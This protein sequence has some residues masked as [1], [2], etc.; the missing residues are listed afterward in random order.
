MAI[1]LDEYEYDNRIGRRISYYASS[2][3]TGHRQFDTNVLPVQGLISASRGHFE[4][5][6]CT[7][8]AEF[9]PRTLILNRIRTATYPLFPWS[10][11]WTRQGARVKRDVIL[12]NLSLL[13][14]KVTRTT[15]FRSSVQI[16]QTTWGAPAQQAV[17]RCAISRATGCVANLRG[18]ERALACLCHKRRLVPTTSPQ[19]VVPRMHMK[20]TPTV[21]ALRSHSGP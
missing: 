14:S 19:S 12:V 2:A 20:R 5:A 11:K 10:L 3:V 9:G 4:C 7:S 18:T 21:D 1:L 15:A 13:E 8:H 17:V 6:R 16:S